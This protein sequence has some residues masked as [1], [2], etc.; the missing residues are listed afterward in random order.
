MSLGEWSDPEHALA[1][2]AALLQAPLP[3]V[4]PSLSAVIGE[5]VPHDALLMLT[6]DCIAA[7]LRSCG[8][9]ELTGR[10]ET[11]ELTRVAGEVRVGEPWCGTITLGHATRQ[12]LAVASSPP[13][14]AGSLLAVV[15]PG[16]A[17]PDP[18]RRRTVQRLWDLTV[19]QIRTLNAQVEPGVLERSRI[20]TGERER[21]VAELADA[22][23]ATL[24]ALLGA[25]RSRDLPDGT[26]RR[27][28]TDLAAAALVELRAADEPARDLPGETV[29][30][31][32]AQM[33]D[34]LILLMRHHRI[35]L[36]LAEPPRP[37]RPLPGHV[38]NAA[39]ATVRGS[40][41]ALLDHP[42]AT[43]VRVSWEIEKGTLCVRVRDDGPGV[44]E[45]EDPAVLRLAARLRPFEGRLDLEAVPGWGTSVTARFPFDS[46]ASSR[47]DPLARLNPR[48]VEVLEHLTR[49]RRN[50]QIAERLHI[51]EHTVKYHVANILEKLG[52]GSRGEATA[53]VLELGPSPD[54]FRTAVS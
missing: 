42:G 16:E 8:D 50:R 1:A 25:L 14:S 36:E 54:V 30:D 45:A 35:H 41:L 3:E 2:V 21:A 4:L 22:H 39:R 46:A 28:A 6:G 48:E 12:V 37:E 43:R 18:A 49:G 40:V 5:L 32:Y 44:L 52:V 31:A 27:T 33:A 24:T 13:G 23:A 26:A 15:L 7:P 11:T 53:L 51:S 29:G 38:A 34:K 20:A 19:V 47:A 9:A 10:A 17:P